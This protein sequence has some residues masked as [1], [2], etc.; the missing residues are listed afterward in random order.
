MAYMNQTRKAIIAEKIKP[1]LA[2]YGVKGS[3]RTT[4]HSITLTLR[5]GKIDF[6]GDMVARFTAHGITY[7]IMP[8]IG[9]RDVAPKDYHFDVNQY[10][11]HEH[12]TGTSKAFIVEALDALKAA[13]W[14][15]RSDAQV[16]YFDTAYYINL[17]VGDWNK[18][19]IVT[20]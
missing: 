8:E 4:K 1:V 5:S 14:Y 20:R 6:I 19:Y 10:W 13:S 18:P 9:N 15:D 12:Y 16:D 7:A 2:K 17:K 3:L 11:Y